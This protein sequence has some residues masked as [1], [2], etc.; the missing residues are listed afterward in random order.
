MRMAMKDLT[1]SDGTFIPAKTIIVAPS[2]LL[3]EFDSGVYDVVLISSPR[4]IREHGYV[5]VLTLSDVDGY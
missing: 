5:K 4:A 3:G 2:I 1:L